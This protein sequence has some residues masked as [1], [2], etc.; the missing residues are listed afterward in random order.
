[1]TRTGSWVSVED[2][3]GR[4]VMRQLYVDTWGRKC[5]RHKGCWRLLTGYGMPYRIGGRD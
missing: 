4:L 3:S 1:M 2:E 5:V